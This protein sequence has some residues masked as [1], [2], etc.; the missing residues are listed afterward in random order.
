M[1]IIIIKIHLKKSLE[2]GSHN[3]NTIFRLLN[4]K[5]Y[6]IIFKVSIFKLFPTL[7]TFSNEPALIV[8]HSVFQSRCL[9]AQFPAAA[10]AVAEVV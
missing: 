9:A 3:W 1:T 8:L 7:F 5:L 6:K 2:C 10:L 4:K